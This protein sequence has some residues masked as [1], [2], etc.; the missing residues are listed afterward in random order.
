LWGDKRPANGQRRTEQFLN[1]AKA[2]AHKELLPLA[3]PPALEVT[4]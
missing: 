4:R 2:L 3:P 1:R